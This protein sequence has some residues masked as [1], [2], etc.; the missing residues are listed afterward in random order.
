M[1]LKDLDKFN[2]NNY[3][4][5]VRITNSCQ[6]LLLA[7]EFFLKLENEMPKLIVATFSS[8]SSLNPYWVSSIKTAGRSMPSIPNPIFL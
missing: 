2:K 1:G 8:L 6:R 7:F 4:V 5:F 3:F